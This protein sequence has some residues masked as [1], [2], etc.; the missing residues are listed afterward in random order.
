MFR[1]DAYVRVGGYRAPFVVAQD[2]DL[3][4]RLA[5]EAQ[6]LGMDQVLYQARLEAGSI[7]SRRRGEQFR[8][9]RL[10]LECKR[11]RARVGNDALTLAGTDAPLTRMGR[12]T[13]AERA[14][15]HYFVASC[16]KQRDRTVARAYYG[17]AL[18]ENPLHLKALVHWVIS[19]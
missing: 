1:R 17:A 7:S 9:A 3:W 4:L 12:V 19:Q 16:I 18:R 5:E 15:F 6:C 11:A 10:A 14:R 8:M 2:L 13:R